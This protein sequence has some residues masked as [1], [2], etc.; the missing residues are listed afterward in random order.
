MKQETVVNEHGEK[1]HVRL[2]EKQISVHHEDYSEEFIP[3]SEF[4][5]EVI[6]DKEELILIFNTI[7]KLAYDSPYVF[8]TQIH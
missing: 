2:I 6:L 1:I 3:I 5:Y 8:I 7:K 4:L